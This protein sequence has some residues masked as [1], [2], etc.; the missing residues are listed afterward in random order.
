MLAH[1]ERNWKNYLILGLA[2]V[3]V[4]MAIKVFGI[5]LQNPFPNLQVQSPVTFGEAAPAEITAPTVIVTA[6]TVP[7]AEDTAPVVPT[8][9]TPDEDVFAPGSTYS[10][11]PA[12]ENI[13]G[14][15][16]KMD[17]AAVSDPAE[18]NTYIVI[19]GDLRA[20]RESAIAVFLTVKAARGFLRDGTW[21]VQYVSVTGD[22]TLDDYLAT[23]NARLG[24]TYTVVLKPPVP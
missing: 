23:L 6:N 4:A 22:G 21:V 1:F 15:G 5:G 13:W 20:R 7:A 19:H 9:P 18:T 17:W 12:G 24:G 10:E 14:N 2:L 8:V 3:V 11:T 16:P